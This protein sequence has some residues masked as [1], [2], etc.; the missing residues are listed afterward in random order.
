[1]TSENNENYTYNVPPLQPE[2][3]NPPTASE[4]IYD[5]YT[6]RTGEFPNFRQRPFHEAKEEFET[7]FIECE[8]G[9]PVEQARSI[10]D[11]LIAT[12]SYEQFRGDLANVWKE[13][14][15][16]H[17]LEK[18]SYMI[19]SGHTFFSD[20]PTIGTGVVDLRR[21]DPFAA[22]RNVLIAG[23]MVPGIEV[24][25]FKNGKYL[26]V[27]PMLRWITRTLQNVP[28]IPEGSS[29]AME[30]QRRV[31]NEEMKEYFSLLSSVPG[32]IFLAA[33]SGTQDSFSADGKRI[34]MHS[35]SEVFAEMLVNR[36]LRILPL[37]FMC[38]SF[39]GG[40]HPAEAKYKFGKIRTN[41]KP[42]DAY[43]I[44][45]EIAQMGT[46]T[47]ADDGITVEYN[48][49][50]RKKVKSTLGKVAIAVHDKATN[51]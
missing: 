1:M 20:L 51:R 5:I 41:T 42:E 4:Q 13:N 32:N 38:D 18:H 28:S 43:E 35:M 12:K 6:G 26:P 10:I 2:Q 15:I 24:D 37:F 25:L 44:M 14:E 45:E 48:P 39:T 29:P 33:G 23:R 21:H 7:P 49:S 50:L 8:L 27:S 22:Q 47:L 11:L 30:A 36:R 17:G 31:W 16:E 46:E 19:L 3:I 9:V 40:L 34:T